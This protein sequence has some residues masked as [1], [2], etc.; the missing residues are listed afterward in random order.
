MKMI[1]LAAL[2]T[3]L[4]NAAIAQ[5]AN[6]NTY[7]RWDFTANNGMHG[8]VIIDAGFCHYTVS[9]AFSSAQSRCL[10]F[11][12]E[13]SNTLIIAP[14]ANVRAQSFSVPE[15]RAERGPEIVAPQGDMGFTFHM[16]RFGVKWMSGHL[17][18]AGEHVSVR[19]TRH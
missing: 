9:S 11:W 16:T 17:V 3:L 18:G 14:P 15:Y 12:R 1:L 2:S 8:S 5:E 6:P 19:L 13:D 7:G 4:A 10:A